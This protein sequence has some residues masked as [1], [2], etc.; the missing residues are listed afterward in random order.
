[1][2]RRLYRQ[3][4]HFLRSQTRTV[5]WAAV[6]RQRSVPPRQMSLICVS[7]GGICSVRDG[8]DSGTEDDVRPDELQESVTA[9]SLDRHENN[10]KF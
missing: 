9:Q 3:L 8:V 1:M 7:P 2:C 4:T 6:Y 5:L 10:V